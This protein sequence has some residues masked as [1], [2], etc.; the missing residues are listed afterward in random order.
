MAV[1]AMASASTEA[2]DTVIERVSP[3][4]FTS[5]TYDRAESTQTGREVETPALERVAAVDEIRAEIL[6]GFRSES[7]GSASPYPRSLEAT[8]AEQAADVSPAAPAGETVPGR[9]IGGEPEPASQAL[10]SHGA[11]P[12]ESV[13][14]V[15]EKPANPR[16][17]WW[18]RFIPS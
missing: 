10:S 12:S 11:P 17:G 13:H 4:E 6:G 14:Q 15:S 7:P 5:E 18:Q 9:P 2:H 1:E 8:G 16:R 3:P